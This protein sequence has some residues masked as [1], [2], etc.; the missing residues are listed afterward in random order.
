MSSPFKEVQKDPDVCSNCFRRTHTR[1][2]RK[3]AVD[4]WWTGSEY[5]FWPRRV[6]RG[7]EIRRIRGTTVKVPEGEPSHG[8]KTVCACGRQYSPDHEWKTRPLDKK[9]FFEY[10]DRLVD[11]F[12][13][14]GV[15]FDEDAFYDQL[16]AKKSDPDQQFADDR[17]YHEAI[18]FA[19]KLSSI[20]NRISA[21]RSRDQNGRE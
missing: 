6:D 17:I 14:M 19:S 18:K 5:E 15:D 11:R 21:Q 20:R 16:D 8:E 9:T 10:A 3:Y 1:W 2:N 12:N 13:E 7:E 4:F